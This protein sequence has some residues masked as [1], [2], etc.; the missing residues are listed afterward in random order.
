MIAKADQRWS[1]PSLAMV[2]PGMLAPTL[3]WLISRESS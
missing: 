2:S 1:A 3:E